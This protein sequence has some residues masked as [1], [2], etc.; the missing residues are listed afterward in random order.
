MTEASI[1]DVRAT[2]CTVSDADVATKYLFELDNG[3]SV[4]S[5]VMHDHERTTVC[6]SSQVGCAMACDFCAT[7]KMGFFRNL[8][9]SEILDQF[10]AIEKDLSEGEAVTNIVFM[11][12]GRAVSKLRSDDEMNRFACCRVRTAT[13]CPKNESPSRPWGLVPQMRQFAMEGL[14]CNLALSLNAATDAV[15]TRLMPIN[16]KYPIDEAL[17]AAKEWALATKR[18]VTLEYVLIRDVNDTDADAKRLRKLM[19]RLPCKLNL[20]PFNEIE[21]SE[22][23]RPEAPSHRAFPEHCRRRAARRSHPIQQRTRYRRRLRST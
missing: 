22:F 7:G 3:D 2:R 1:S 10:T 14:K 6:M 9:A 23:R 17:D 11:G 15:R 19:S 12:N 13:G 5:V 16:E 20:I 21:D 18:K 4:E 8:S